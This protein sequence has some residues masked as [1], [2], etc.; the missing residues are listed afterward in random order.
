MSSFT[1][2]VFPAKPVDVV[3]C[4]LTWLRLKTQDVGG[5]GVTA[6]S[7]AAL[8]KK[9]LRALGGRCRVLVGGSRKEGKAP[10]PRTRRHVGGVR[11]SDAPPS[12]C[13]DPVRDEPPTWIQGGSTASSCRCNP[14]DG[15]PISLEETP[16]PL[17]IHGVVLKGNITLLASTSK[18]LL[19]CASLSHNL[20]SIFNSQKTSMWG[21]TDVCVVQETPA[22][23]V[24]DCTILGEVP[25][26]RHELTMMAS[27]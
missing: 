15:A 4:L 20:I 2:F 14:T 1:G 5:G 13:R 19:G 8:Q 21:G 7:I 6:T 17:P 18:T 24:H 10:R 9:P 22:G 23:A 11:D 3:G 16:S 25:L 26:L 12:R 27:L